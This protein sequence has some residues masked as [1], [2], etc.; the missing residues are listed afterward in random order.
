MYREALSNADKQI[1][2][3]EQIKAEYKANKQDC[4]AQLTTME[5][6]IKSRDKDIRKLKTH[7]GI[8]GTVAV[9]L[10]GVIVYLS[11]DK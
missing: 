2:N 8:L 1:Q 3:L 11:I 4:E 7:R 6:T 10:A 9:V 5:K